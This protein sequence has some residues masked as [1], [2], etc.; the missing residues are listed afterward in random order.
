M[1]VKNTTPFAFGVKST[2]TSPP[3]PQMTVV[4]RGVFDIVDG[5]RCRIVEGLPLLAQ[6]SLTHDRC[7]DG[8]D[9]RIGELTYADDFAD[10]KPRADVLLRG[11]CHTPD[12]EPIRGCQVE[13]AVGDWSKRLIVYGAR[14]WQ[15]RGIRR[16]ASAPK[17]FAAM[18]LSYRN[19]FGGNGF[20]LN[21]I[22]KG[23]EADELPNIEW[24]GAEINSPSPAPL[25]ANFGPVSPNWPQRRSKLQS[26]FGADAVPGAAYYPQDFDW[27][28]FNAA[29]SDQQIEGFLRGDERIRL[30][31]LQPE[32]ASLRSR[33]PTLRIR[34]FVMLA[35]VVKEHE[36]RLDTLFIDADA[37]TVTLCWRGQCDIAEDDLSDVSAMLIASEQL[38]DEAKPAR[39]YEAEL[40]AFERDPVGESASEDT[41]AAWAAADEMKN[42]PSAL[43][44]ARA[45]VPLVQRYGKPKDSAALERSLDKLDDAT[46]R[47]GKP[48]ADAMAA[49]SA[50]ATPVGIGRRPGQ[51][52]T[53]GDPKLKSAVDDMRGQLA[54][55]A[56]SVGASQEPALDAVRAKLDHPTLQAVAGPIPDP[57]S[58]P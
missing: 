46:L 49:P 43:S 53:I 17:P 57:S 55:D 34:S 27:S 6:G 15:R 41:K 40:A 32:T 25:P 45:A 24:V 48:L 9:D 18:P 26:A 33:L 28:Y 3:Q 5:G 7:V 50:S 16:V 12:G 31:H 39:E 44:A 36:M 10:Y 52:P 8:D 37:Q 47:D 30:L 42:A 13:V 1:R 21:P 23:H 2:S 38:G 4:V 54:P 51:L 19:S 11:T 29:P 20:A 35:G 56:R 14:Q 22:G 58:L